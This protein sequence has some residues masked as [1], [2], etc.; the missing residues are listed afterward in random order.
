MGRAVKMQQRSARTAAK[1]ARAVDNKA[2]PGTL[3]EL[4]RSELVKLAS[5]QGISGRSG[6]SKPQL[7]SALN[8]NKKGANR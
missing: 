1:V 7:V 6:M 2:T 8:K 4:P 5:A 3:K